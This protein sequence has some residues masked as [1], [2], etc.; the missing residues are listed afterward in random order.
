MGNRQNTVGHRRSRILDDNELRKLWQ[1]TA[2]GTPFAS[3]VRFLLLTSARRNEAAGMK[4]DE[5]DADGVWTLPESRSKTKVD[6]IRPLSKAA[7]AILNEQPRISDHVFTSNGVTPIAS[8]SDP[9]AALDARSRVVGWRLHDLRRSARS[10]LS[11]A[12]VNSDVAEKCLGHSRGDII[13]R[14]DQHKYLDEMT[15]ALEAL[16][17]L[18]AR[19]INPPEGGVADLATERKRRR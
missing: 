16:S 18:I 17:A 6:V 4:W 15:H 10:L 13:E 19:I 11:R 1:A 3:L 9:K 8:F 12:G 5:I 2:D 14:Y 7:L